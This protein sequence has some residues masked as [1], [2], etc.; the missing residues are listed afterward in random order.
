MDSSSYRCQAKVGEFLGQ[1]DEINSWD[2][3]MNLPLFDQYFTPHILGFDQFAMS[4]QN[5]EAV[6]M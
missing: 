3:T 2:F 1:L 4:N 5:K 6:N